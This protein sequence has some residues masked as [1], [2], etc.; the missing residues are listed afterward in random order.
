MPFEITSYLFAVVSARLRYY[1][2]KGRCPCRHR[3]RPSNQTKNYK[4]LRRLLW[5]S[6]RRLRQYHPCVHSS[7][8]QAAQLQKSRRIAISFSLIQNFCPA[9]VRNFSAQHL[10]TPSM[11]SIPRL[12]AVRL[13]QISTELDLTSGASTPDPQ[14]YEQFLENIQKNTNLNLSL[15]N[16]DKD[17]E[18]QHHQVPRATPHHFTP[19]S[20][21]WS[22]STSLSK[23]SSHASEACGM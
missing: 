5:K 16:R 23:S 13:A 17:G 12:Y 1:H 3:R 10:G 22:M 19:S 7:I 18:Q 21:I 2:G 11:P 20:S 9:H 14:A 15:Q 6:P 8:P 4:E